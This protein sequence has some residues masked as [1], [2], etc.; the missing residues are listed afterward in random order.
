MSSTGLSA[1]DTVVNKRGDSCPHGTYILAVRLAVDLCAVIFIFIEDMLKTLLPKI[2]RWPHISCNM[3]QSME[4]RQ[5]GVGILSTFELWDAH[6]FFMMH[7]LLYVTHALGVA[8][9]R[10]NALP[11]LKVLMIFKVRDT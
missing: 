7:F 11:R 2:T 5:R 3:F 4:T 10:I 9:A 1:K 6:S 8:G